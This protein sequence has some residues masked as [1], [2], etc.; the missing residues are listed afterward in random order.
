MNTKINIRPRILTAILLIS[1]SCPLLAQTTPV[2]RLTQAMALEREGK[3]APAIAEIKRLLDSQGVDPLST[4]KA[5]HIQ[6]LAYQDQGEFTLSQHTYEESLRILESLPDNIQDYAIVLDDFG[7]LYLSTGQF[8]IANKMKTKALGLFEKID[9]HAGIVRASY[10]L[11]T[12]AF[13]QKKV[14]EGSKYLKSAMKEARAANGLNDDDRATIASLQGWQA[15]FD[16]DYPLSTAK[17]RQALDLWRSLHGEEHPYTGWGYLLLGDADAA[18]GQLT[19]ALQE[20]KQSMDILDRS[21]GRQNPRYLSAEM[22]YAR[23]LDVA[24]FQSKAAQIRSAAE[25]LL[26]DID[27]R[28]CAGCT[29]N[30]TTFY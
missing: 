24:G 1:T 6:G 29:L 28:Q 4:A 30:S 10:N 20:I 13:S 25:P 2:E 19:A 9:D 8:E 12:I 15:Q 5:W 7:G 23:V 11:A 26:K 18:A 16:G 3:T 17:Y 14:A 27:R 21:L 22:A